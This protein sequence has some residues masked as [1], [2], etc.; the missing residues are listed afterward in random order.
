M[1][2]VSFYGCGENIQKM[3]IQTKESKNENKEAFIKAFTNDV[4]MKAFFT[5]AILNFNQIK[6]S[7]SFY[8][9]AFTLQSQNFFYD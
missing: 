6:F 5:T 8:S 4:I 9:F 1:V 7:I 2:L 3:N